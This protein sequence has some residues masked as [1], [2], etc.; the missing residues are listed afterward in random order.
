MVYAAKHESKSNNRAII[1][2]WIKAHELF[3]TDREVK[4]EEEEEDE[5]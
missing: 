3:I 2:K 1:I 5:A 4:E